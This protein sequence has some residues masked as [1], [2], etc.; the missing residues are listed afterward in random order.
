MKEKNFMDWLNL[1]SSA[2]A[3]RV[4]PKFEYVETSHLTQ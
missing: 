2:G 1:M 4:A 3:D